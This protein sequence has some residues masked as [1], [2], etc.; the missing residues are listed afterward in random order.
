MYALTNN[1]FKEQISPSMHYLI[2]YNNTYFIYLFISYEIVDGGNSTNTRNPNHLPF[3]VDP[4]T[5]PVNPIV[6][7]NWS[8]LK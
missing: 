4:N 5:N 3:L 8:S 1:I 2:A 7:S 6:P